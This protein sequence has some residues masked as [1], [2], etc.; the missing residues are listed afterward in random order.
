MVNKFWVRSQ[1]SGAG[2]SIDHFYYI[3][4]NPQTI[5]LNLI[6]SNVLE[7]FISA[8]VERVV[9]GRIFRKTFRAC[10]VVPFRDTDYQPLTGSG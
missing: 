3:V 6:N 1:K 4:M 10:S 5:C 2:E 8:I 9:A 7:I